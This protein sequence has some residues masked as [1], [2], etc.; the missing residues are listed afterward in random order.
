MKESHGVL[1][2]NERQLKG[3][4]CPSVELRVGADCPGLQWICIPMQGNGFVIPVLIRVVLIRTDGSAGPAAQSF[5]PPPCWFC[6]LALTFLDYSSCHR[7]DCWVGIA[8]QRLEG[9]NRR[10]KSRDETPQPA[11]SHQHPLWTTPAPPIAFPGQE[12]H[13]RLRDQLGAPAQE[14]STCPRNVPLPLQHCLAAGQ[15]SALAQ[16]SAPA[17]T[18]LPSLTTA[19]YIQLL[20]ALVSGVL[21]SQP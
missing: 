9:F 13:M 12:E 15:G 16:S 6:L 14:C 11:E 17:H 20:P 7:T 19:N 8:S 4:V 10:K 3:L 2:S 18:A 5:E 21:Q 1:R